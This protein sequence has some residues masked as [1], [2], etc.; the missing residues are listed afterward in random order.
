MADYKL[1][2]LGLKCPMPVLK[3]KKMIKQ[4]KSG[5]TLELIADDMGAKSDI[6]A[7]LNKNDCT[8]VELKEEGGKLTF[9]IKKN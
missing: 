7:L 1:D 2:A 5:E 3:A 6:P 4:M 9:L 8:L